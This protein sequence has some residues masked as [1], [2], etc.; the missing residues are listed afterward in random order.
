M[1]FEIKREGDKVCV[2]REQFNGSVQKSL[3]CYGGGNHGYHYRLFEPF[4]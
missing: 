4:L 3:L 1:H 2:R